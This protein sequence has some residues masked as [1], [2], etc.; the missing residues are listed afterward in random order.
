[1]HNMHGIFYTDK[2]N[3]NTC[4]SKTVIQKSSYKLSWLL[5]QLSNTLLPGM[6]LKGYG[7]STPQPKRNFAVFQGRIDSTMY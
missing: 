5:E 2:S 6:K 7:V 1:M 3:F 4:I